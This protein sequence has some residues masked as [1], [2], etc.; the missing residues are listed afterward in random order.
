MVI[1]IVFVYTKVIQ[2]VYDDIIY[3]FQ[4][5]FLIS[6]N[7]LVVCCVYQCLQTSIFRVYLEKKQINW[8]MQMMMKK[9][10]SLF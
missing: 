1:L 2:N 9:H 5:S 7:V 6:L 10:V 8:S 4:K 3:I